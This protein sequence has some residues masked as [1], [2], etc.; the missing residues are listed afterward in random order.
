[1]DKTKVRCVIEFLQLQGKT[2]FQMHDFYGVNTQMMTKIQFSVASLGSSTLKC[3][4]CQPIIVYW[5]NES[6]IKPLG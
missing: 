3:N 2:A 6:D 4:T 1:M 5:R